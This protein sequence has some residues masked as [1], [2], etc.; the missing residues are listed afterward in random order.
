MPRI[1]L[2]PWFLVCVGGA[3][4][5]IL[6][7]YAGIIFGPRAATTFAVNITGT[8]LI[9]VLAAMTNDTRTRLLLGTGLLGGFTTFSTWQL[10]VYAAAHTEGGFR[11]ALWIVFGSVAAGS[12]S[13]WLGFSLGE[14][15]R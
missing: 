12:L 10:E 14:R 5:S 2:E 7:Y 3:V 9:G 13:C 11:D 8:F 1:F 4:G 6:R 15:L